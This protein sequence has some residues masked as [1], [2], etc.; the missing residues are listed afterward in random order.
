MTR[1][2]DTG[3]WRD[4]RT[5]ELV[6]RPPVAGHLIVPPG[7]EVPDDLLV[8]ESAAVA[9]PRETADAPTETMRGGSDDEQIPETMAEVKAWVGDDAQRALRAIDGELK[10]SKPRRSLVKHLEQVVADARGDG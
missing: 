8:V 2:S 10:R 9:A 3:I 7:A 1:T 6:T 4:K 5:G